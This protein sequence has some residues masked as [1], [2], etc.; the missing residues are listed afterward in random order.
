VNVK[1]SKPIRY[2][3]VILAAKTKGSRVAFTVIVF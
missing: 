3:F 2:M 1:G